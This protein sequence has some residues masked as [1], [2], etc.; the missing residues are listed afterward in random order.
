[1]GIIPPPTSGYHDQKFKRIGIY[2]GTLQYDDAVA[3]RECNGMRSVLR[4]KFPDR[5]L[6]ML[7]NGSFGDVQNSADFRRGFSVCYPSQNFGLASRQY[8][9]FYFAA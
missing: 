3:E 7:V 4:A 9:L 1:M 2:D 8:G 5:R 6:N